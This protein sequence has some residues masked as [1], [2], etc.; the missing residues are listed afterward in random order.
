MEQRESL[1]IGEGAG[2]T[3]KEAA[4]PEGSSPSYHQYPGLPLPLAADPLPL[5]ASKLLSSFIG[6][7]RLVIESHL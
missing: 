3:E 4:E 2:Q 7:K 6:R 1:S 5:G